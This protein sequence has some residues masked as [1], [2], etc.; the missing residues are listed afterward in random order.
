[1][2]RELHNLIDKIDEDGFVYCE[3]KLGMYGLKQAS[4]LAYIQLRG[5]LIKHGYAP[6]KEYTGLWKHTTKKTIFALCIDDSGIK[7]YN[8]DDAEHLISTL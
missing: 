4:I 5:S 2:R 7:Y 3:V 6:I 1:M 8:T